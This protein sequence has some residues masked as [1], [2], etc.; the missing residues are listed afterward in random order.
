M[1]TFLN[2]SS[3]SSENRFTNIVNSCVIS[4]EFRFRTTGCAV[5]RAT[6]LQTLPSNLL[7]KLISSRSRLPHFCTSLIL[8]L[9]TFAVTSLCLFTT[10]I[11]FLIPKHFS[12]FPAVF[13]S[14]LIH[15]KFLL[16][17][18]ST[19]VFLHLLITRYLAFHFIM[20][21]VYGKDFIVDQLDDV[22]CIRSAQTLYSSM[23]RKC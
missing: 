15:H 14:H 5:L 12:F 18:Y 21:G 11:A 22:L 17:K 7:R 13:Y 9:L 4:L 10:S 16:C 23:T 8:F 20:P 19:N 3:V 2:S 1:S 6:F